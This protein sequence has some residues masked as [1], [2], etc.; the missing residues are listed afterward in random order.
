[1]KNFKVVFSVMLS[2]CIMAVCCKPEAIS[3]LSDDGSVPGKLTNVQ[4]QPLAGAAKIKYTLPDNTNLL[5]IKAEYDLNGTKMEV[6]SSFY[7]NSLIVEGFGDTKEHEVTLYAVSRAEKASEPV[8]VMVTPLTP[9]VITIRNSFFVKETFGGIYVKF[10]NP[11]TANVVIKV[12][13]KDSATNQWNNINNFYTSLSEGQFATRGL[14]SKPTDFAIFVQDRWNNRSDTLFTNLTPVFEEALDKT[15]WSDQ[16][17]KW[18]VPQVAPLPESGLPVAEAVDYSGSYPIRNLYD[19][20]VTSMFHTK[21]KFDIPI[22]V[23]IDLGVKATLSRYKI[24]QRSGTAY[25]FNHGNP[26]KWQIWGTNDPANVNSWVLLTEQ[27]MEKP[28]G[29]P[30]GTNSNDDNAAALNGQEYDFPIGVPPVRYIS[31]KMID[32]WASI[33]GATGHLHLMELSIWGQKQ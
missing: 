28:S 4:V 6:K 16:R 31:F 1:M 23:P 33:G 15:K 26:H 12:L 20:N 8:K 10:K 17:K 13:L 11:D 29:Q 14:P 21:E 32:S 9:P 2:V 7:N 30:V 19:G 22:W 24:W 18:P 27:V 5:Y 3:P 25:N